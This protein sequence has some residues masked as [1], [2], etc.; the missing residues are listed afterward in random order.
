MTINQAVKAIDNN[1]SYQNIGRRL[2]AMSSA[3][4]VGNFGGHRIGFVNVP[5]IYFIKKKGYQLLTDNELPFEL[6]GN[7]KEKSSPHWSTQ[8]NHRIKLIDIFLSLESGI[9]KNEHLD[10]ARVFLEYNRIKQG[11]EITSE[12]T[13]YVADQ[14]TTENKIVPDGA[15][16]IESLKT[17]NRVLFLVEMDMG[18]ESI[19]SRVSKNSNL[20][21]YGRIKKYDRYLISGKYVRKYGE[22]GSFDH[23]VLLFITL[24]GK[25][26]ENIRGELFDL[27]EQFHGYYMFNTY[28]A[29]VKD[30]FNNQWKARSIKDNRGHSLLG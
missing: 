13:D 22:W 30:F 14:E 6:L 4:Y 12:T 25:R 18:T 15:F 29:V 3:G 7:F 16:I 10:L 2:R 26:M 5:K 20:P 11:K 19:V 28:E 8:T 9:R 17:E 23:F 27:P 1:R 21:L 24:S